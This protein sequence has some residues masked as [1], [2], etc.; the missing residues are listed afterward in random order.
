LKSETEKELKV[1]QKKVKGLEAKE[2]SENKVHNSDGKE[3]LDMAV[4]LRLNYEA[5]SVLKKLVEDREGVMNVLKEMYFPK[6]SVDEDDGEVTATK[7]NPI[8]SINLTI[9]SDA[10]VI[11]GGRI[12]PKLPLG[13]LVQGLDSELAIL[14]KSLVEVYE[15][16]HKEGK[17]R[18]PDEKSR[19]LYT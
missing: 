2:G 18:N 14:I 3:K 17:K 12:N 10:I 11:S 9:D 16:N 19:L 7:A 6:V 1:V 5:D 4:V 15:K 8:C 13:V